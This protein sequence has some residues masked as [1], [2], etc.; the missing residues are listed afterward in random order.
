MR[1]PVPTGLILAGR[2]QE[3]VKDLSIC[4]PTW[5]LKLPPA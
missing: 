1:P 3:D 2:F 4:R 5:S